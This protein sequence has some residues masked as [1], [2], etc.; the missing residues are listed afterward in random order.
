MIRKIHVYAGGGISPCLKTKREEAV[1]MSRSRMTALMLAL[2]V[3]PLAVLAS[4]CGGGGEE[5]T[6]KG[7]TVLKQSRV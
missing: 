4:G 3:A 2:L 1:K 7:E 6:L 5:Q